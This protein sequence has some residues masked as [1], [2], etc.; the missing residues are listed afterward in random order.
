MNL[1]GIDVGTTSLKA[2]CFRDNGER[3]HEVNLDYTLSTEGDRVEFD[4]AEYVRIAKKAIEEIRSVCTVDAIS[5]DTQGETMI[6]TDE[7]GNPTM[8]AIVWLDNRA[9]KEAEEIAEKFG[10]ETLYRTT[11]QA[12]CTGGWPCCK[13]LWVQRNLPEAW[14][15]TKKIF[16]LEDWLLWA[17]SGEFVTEPTIQ[18]SSLYLDITKEDWWDE[19][20][21]YIGID[22]S[23]LPAIH[24]AGTKIGLFDG[25]PVVTGAL[26]QIAG[27]VGVGVVDGSVVSEMTGT[28]MA[29]CAVTESIPPFDPDSKIP[30]H[31]H[32]LK[33]K[34]VSLLW[35]STAGMALKWFRNGFAKD[36]SFRELDEL[37]AK[38]P[39]GCEG[40]T[41]LPHLC[42]STMPV[43]NPDARGTFWG[44][45]LAHGVGHFA[46]SI[47]EAVAFTLKDD[48]ECIGAK[49]DEIRITGGG[50]SS[51]LWAQIKADVT[52]LKLC[53]LKEKESACLGTAILAGVGVGI[54]ASV[55]EACQRLVKTEKV[56]APQGTDYC[57]AYRQ[58]K[59]LDRLLNDPKNVIQ[60]KAE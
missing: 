28:I 46:R 52:G 3:L 13:V 55:E 22:R 49:C 42:G 16:L 32:A 17:L 48:L 12:E 60:E 34:Y 50:A 57:A 10:L 25:I 41:M 40:L 4:P 38:V 1:L 11:G 5:I 54:Y 47:L 43:Y 24:P 56:Y 20:L 51:P 53:T 58:Y 6:L 39:A 29:I 37:A 2:V 35:S 31:L 33:G 27:A 59:K 19:M 15:K 7:N 30:C 45:T 26:D 18:S 21:E 23:Y 36:L 14:K 9:T 8:P 44:M